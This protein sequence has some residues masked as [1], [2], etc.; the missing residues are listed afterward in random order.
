MVFLLL[1]LCLNVISNSHIVCKSV[2][3]VSQINSLFCSC[4]LNVGNSISDFHI[5]CN[6]VM[7]AQEFVHFAESLF[8]KFD[9][10]LIKQG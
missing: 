9:N 8:V 10:F 1:S 5:F 7:L 2:K 4:A 6:F 3:H